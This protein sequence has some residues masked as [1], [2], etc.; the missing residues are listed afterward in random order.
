MF[1]HFII[2]FLVL[3]VRASKRNFKV[4]TGMAIW[5]ICAHFVDIYWQVLPTFH[6]AEG[7]TFHWLDITCILAI[8]SIFALVFWFKMNVTRCC[9]LA[10]RGLN[11]VWNL[12]MHKASQKRLEGL[13]IQ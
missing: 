7:V 3:V 11:K 1:G 10:I 13:G 2:P 12:K 8:G 6:H 5:I 9:R 4:L